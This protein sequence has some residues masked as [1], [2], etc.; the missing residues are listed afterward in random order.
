MPVTA[1]RRRTPLAIPSDSRTLN[2]WIS[3]VLLTWLD[4]MR[5]RCRAQVVSGVSQPMERTTR[6]THVPPQNSTLVF[7][8]LGFSASFAISSTS[9]SSVTTRTGSG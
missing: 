2:D 1:I 4:R 5:A 9:Y 3:D 7:R 8:H 6:Q